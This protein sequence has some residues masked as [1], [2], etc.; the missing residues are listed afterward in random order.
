M[1]KNGVEACAS[2]DSS[3]AIPNLCPTTNTSHNCL[4]PITIYARFGS[5]PS[6]RLLPFVHAQFRAGEAPYSTD[7]YLMVNGQDYVIARSIE[8]YNGCRPRQHRRLQ[9]DGPRQADL[10]PR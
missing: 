3:E 8:Q 10:G 2:S 9:H 5:E 6:G 1:S 7:E 4:E